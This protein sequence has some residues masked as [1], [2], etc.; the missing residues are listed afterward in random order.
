MHQRFIFHLGE[1]ECIKK[2]NKSGRKFSPSIGSTDNHFDSFKKFKSMGFPVPDSLASQHQ[3]QHFNGRL[4]SVFL[5]GRHINIINKVDK[6][7][8]WWRDQGD[9]TMFSQILEF[10]FK[11]DLSN[12]WRGLGCEGK[13][14]AGLSTIFDDL[15]DDTC[16]SCTCWRSQKNWIKFL[17]KK[18]NYRGIA[19]GFLRWHKNVQI[20][21]ILWELIFWHQHVP[22][23]PLSF[24]SILEIQRKIVARTL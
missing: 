15:V 23:H 18:F 2:S 16:L 12:W 9:W 11:L 10:A 5:D 7:L 1:V 6:L 22:W 13:G 21:C 19:E 17:H 8:S 4:S 24:R 3:S 20:A 14:E